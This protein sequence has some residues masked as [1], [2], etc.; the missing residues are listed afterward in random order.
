MT[1]FRSAA[2][3]LIPPPDNIS[4][5][6]FILDDL[7]KHPTRP[8]RSRDI[9]CFIEQ[10]TNRTVFFDELCSR[11][12]ALARAMKACWT[13]G[14]DDIISAFTPN[15]I[16]YPVC[17]WAAHRLGAIVALMSPM[18]TVEELAYQLQMTKPRLIIADRDNLSVALRAAHS[19]GLSNDRIVL[20]N[21]QNS[22]AKFPC[23]SL[24]EV[25]ESG[26]ACAA[27]TEFRLSDGQGKEKIA[28]LCFSSGTTGMPKAVAISHYN[29]ACNIIQSATSHRINEDYASW[30]DRRFRPGDICCAVLPFYHIYGFMFNL[31]YMLYAGLTLVIFRKFDHENLLKSIERYRITHLQLVP[32]QVL[33]FCKHPYTKKYDLSSI[34][35]CMVAAA[36][37]TAELTTQLLELFPDV[38]L[39]Q[40]YGLTET[41]A[42]VSFWPIS[43]K[44]GTLG[45]SGQL[46][47]GTLAKV[48]K[49]DGSLAGVGE[50]GE[51]YVRGGQVALGYYHND[52]ATREA[53]IDGWFRTGDEV[54]FHKNGD[55]FITDRIKEL[56]KVKGNQVAPAELEGHLLGHPDVADA[57]VIGLADDFAGEV[58]LAFIVLRPQIAETV[59]KD[60]LAAREVRISIFK[61]V[62]EAKSSYKWPTGGIVFID[63]V[64]KN[65]SGKIL[66]RVLRE[67]AKTLPDIVHSKL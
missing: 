54:V 23:K 10:E 32:P 20:S 4:V 47:T 3:K 26:Y 16:D 55:L 15:H 51:L 61:Y 62:S 57:A 14:V 17:V 6:Q 12:D 30:R 50:R 41:C 52:K 8:I 44:V 58:P 39:G 56:I 1:L 60:K 53:F 22:K 21:I 49:P 37:M 64:P 28:L 59:L 35:C 11:T 66:R 65:A 48:V 29:V 34:R 13:I 25:I 43:Q 5:P 36:P 9:P 19:I 40:G 2:P 31:H 46:V 67:R 45:G 38:H 7:S 24:N 18:L 42:A 33:L 27:I 63:A